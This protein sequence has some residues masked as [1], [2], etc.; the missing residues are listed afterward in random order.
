MFWMTPGMIVATAICLSISKGIGFR[1]LSVHPCLSQLTKKNRG[2]LLPWKHPCHLTGILWRRQRKLWQWVFDQIYFN[3]LA[4]AFLK[5]GAWAEIRS[6]W[7]TERKAQSALAFQWA[8]PDS[9]FLYEF[10]SNFLNNERKTPFFTI[11]PRG[12]RPP[13]PANLAGKLVTFY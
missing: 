12:D 13:I 5:K 2:S 11:P 3:G 7:G 9:E 8:V 4:L 1:F 6:L 10:I